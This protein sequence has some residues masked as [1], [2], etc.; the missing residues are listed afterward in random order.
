LCYHPDFNSKGN[1]GVC[2]FEVKGIKEVV[3]ACTTKVEEGMEILTSSKKVKDVRNLNIELIFAE[4]AMK[5]NT[6]PWS[7]NCPLLKLA[8]R[9]E[10]DTSRFSKRKDTRKIYKFDC[11]IE[12]DNSQCIDCRNCIDACSIQQ[13]IG[14]LEIEGKGF[15]QK[16]VPTKNKNIECI[17]PEKIRLDKKV[18]S[19]I[20]KVVNHYFKTKG[21]TLEELKKSAKKQEIIY[22]RYTKPA[23]QL[24]ELSGSI[25]KA[26]ESITKVA[27]WANSRNLDYTIE[28]VLKKWLE[29]KNLEPKKIEKKPFYRG[30]R[31]V[32]KRGKWY[33][34]DNQ[35]EW[36]EFAGK[37]EDIVWKEE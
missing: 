11:S 7:T 21:L 14:Y 15:E 18:E 19:G 9:Y 4:H 5:C 34:I 36:L 13:G 33:V 2:V 3:R 12:L 10:I 29:I 20:Q 8:R 1:C 28:T 23:K 31:M 16:I 17:N 22:S 35:G 30:D 25:E 6:C 37:E 27:N 24:L 26:K 32:K